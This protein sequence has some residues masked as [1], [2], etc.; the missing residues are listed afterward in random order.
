MARHENE[1]SGTTDVAGRPEFAA[2]RVTRTIDGRPVTGWFT[3]DFTLADVTG[4][5]A[6]L[7][8]AGIDGA[9][10]DDPGTARAV[11]AERARHRR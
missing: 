2:R 11:L 10:C 7:L 5:L 4:W 1:I 8:D 3:E 9:F 6:K